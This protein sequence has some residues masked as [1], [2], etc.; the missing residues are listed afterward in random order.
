[1]EVRQNEV[2]GEEN[3]SADREEPHCNAL[4]L[5]NDFGA[6]MPVLFSFLAMACFIATLF[7]T[8]SLIPSLVERPLNGVFIDFPM[9]NR[10]NK[11][12]PFGDRTS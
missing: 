12:C 10:Q 5:E 7:S 6:F 3:K 2:Y 9:C 11:Q 8:I 4:H 1:M